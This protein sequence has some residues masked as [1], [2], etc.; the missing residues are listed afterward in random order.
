MGV[1]VQTRDQVQLVDVNVSECRKAVEFTPPKLPRKDKDRAKKLKAALMAHA[2]KRW[3]G[4]E[5]A[6][7]D[8]AEA[9]LI[10]LRG[11]MHVEG[12]HPIVVKPRRKPRK[13]KLAA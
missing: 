12:L 7:A 5:F 1:A 8:A 3:P 13:K 2:Q 4:V 11:L 10:A 9:A 6:T